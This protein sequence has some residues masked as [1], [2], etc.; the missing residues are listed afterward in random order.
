[1]AA[2]MVANGAAAQGMDVVMFFTFWGVNLLR[3]DKPNPNEQ[4]EKVS[5]AQRLFKFLMPKGPK[6]QAL[7]QLNFGGFGS[8]M[9]GKIMKQNNVMDLDE[10][11]QA[12]IDLD[13]KFIVCTMSMSVMGITKRDLVVLPN[14]EHAGV[15]TFVQEA[16][17]SE[18]S[19]MF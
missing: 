15:A 8:M 13:V 1:M 2:L 4:K 11:I 18:M 9:L 5:L 7:G 3:G 16:A 17:Q 14:M 12:A 19:M 10:L 6:K